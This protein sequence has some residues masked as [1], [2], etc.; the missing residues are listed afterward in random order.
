MVHRDTG[1]GIR[2]S[3]DMDVLAVWT[4]PGKQAPYLCI[5]PWQGGPAYAD[6]TGRFEDKPYHVAL[7]VGEAYSCGYRMEILD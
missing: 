1:K 3:F 2:V 4:S 5:E 6:E 7:G